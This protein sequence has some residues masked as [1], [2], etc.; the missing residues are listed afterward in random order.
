MEGR[1]WAR[2]HNHEQKKK[3]GSKSAYLGII[4]IRRRSPMA[5]RK[6]KD[7]DALQR[8]LKIEPARNGTRRARPVFYI[9]ALQP[10]VLGLRNSKRPAFNMDYTLGPGQIIAK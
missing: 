2:K 1:I 3:A 9:T 6:S 7:G 8:K 5:K 10:R 4:I